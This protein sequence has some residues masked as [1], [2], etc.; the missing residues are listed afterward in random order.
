[1][2][3]GPWRLRLNTPTKARKVIATSSRRPTERAYIGQSPSSCSGQTDRCLYIKKSSPT[4][5]D[6]GRPGRPPSTLTHQA[7]M[8]PWLIR[9]CSRNRTQSWEK[10]IGVP[11]RP[12][13]PS[14]PRVRG[15]RARN[16][17]VVAK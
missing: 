11:V 17:V 2:I 6:A 14:R 8:K 4:T 16:A 3:R 12:L 9:T 7:T 1:M 10:A 5:N 13:I 15:D